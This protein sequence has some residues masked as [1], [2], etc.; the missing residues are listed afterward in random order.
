M[1]GLFD[2]DGNPDSGWLADP[3]A[4]LQTMLANPAQRN[5]LIA[6]VD[7]AMGGFGDLARGVV[8]TGELRGDLLHP[9]EPVLALARDMVEQRAKVA[10]TAG[11]QAPAV[12]RIAEALPAGIQP[13]RRAGIAER[14]APHAPVAARE[15]LEIVRCLCHASSA[16][17]R[18]LAT[19][20]WRRH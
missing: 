13:G 2:A 5:A 14:L 1:S 18:M 3:G 16:V 10:G 4:S 20:R 15:R 11:L 17:A 7:E 12:E 9:R 8:A 6:F 19:R